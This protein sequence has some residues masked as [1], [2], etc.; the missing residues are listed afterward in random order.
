MQNTEEKP[1]TNRFGRRPHQPHTQG[2]FYCQLQPLC[3]KK[4]KVSCPDPLPKWSPRSIHTTM[5][6]PFAASYGSPASLCPG[7]RTWQYRC[8]HYNAICSQGF[9]K[10]TKL[11]THEQPLM[12]GSTAAAPAAHTR[13]LSSLA[14]ATLPEKTEGFVPRPPSKMKPTQH[15]YNNH[16]A[17]CSITWLTRISLRAWQ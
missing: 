11:R 6:M 2:T 8:S 17:F 1:I 4:Q 5:T 16:N 12:R 3:P 10:R 9:K 15:P 14:A 7:S 13:Y